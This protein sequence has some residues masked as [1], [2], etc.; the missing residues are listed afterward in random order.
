MGS[1]KLER[2]TKQHWRY[3]GG[4]DLL[5]SPI[6]LGTVKFGRNTQVK[7]PQSFTLPTQSQLQALLAYAQQCGINMLDTAPAYGR[8]ETILGTLLKHQREQWILISKAGETYINHHSRFDFRAKAIEHSIEQSLARLKTDFLDIALIHSDGNDEVLI[9]Q[10]EVF[11][12]LAS[13]KSRGLI[14][15]YGMSCKT[16][17]G[18]LATVQHADIAMIAYNLAD[19][20]QLPVLKKANELNKGILIKKALASGHFKALNSPHPLP[21]TYQHLLSLSEHHAIIVGTINPA[22]LQQN[23]QAALQN[24]K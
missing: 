19:R 21:H 18:G 13:L 8:S 14:R 23:I 24:L 9:N 17:A 5:I 22:H 11:D 16:V 7:Y 15:F 4:T 10:F 12:T 20:S 6:G 1:I 2:F 3:L